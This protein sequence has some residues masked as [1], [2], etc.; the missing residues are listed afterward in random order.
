MAESRALRI[1]A[2]WLSTTIQAM[3]QGNAELALVSL[4]QV[5][6]C[7]A[8]RQEIFVV[9]DAALL[10]VLTVDN[11]IQA[12]YQAVFCLWQMS[13]DPQVVGQ[14]QD[15][16]SITRVAATL[17]TVKKEKLARM[18]VAFL[19]NI[20]EKA[21]DV[22]SKRKFASQ[23]I[24]QKVVNSV[25]D[26]VKNKTFLD[27]E[28]IA[29]CEYLLPELL[30]VVEGM[31]SFDEYRTEV[32]SGQLEWSPVHRSERFWR[33]NIN[34][35]NDGFGELVKALVHLLDS[36]PTYE[37]WRPLSTSSNQRCSCMVVVLYRD[38]I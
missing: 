12:Q 21:E 4:Q 32:M 6:W 22:Q 17:R 8:L 7:P 13:F 20:L 29:D 15:S 30:V 1:Y 26:F 23:M 31:S 10:N 19:R 5:L 34:N 27:E 24:G 36:A 28:I 33:D 25:S 35:I 16:P 3:E 18:C 38:E 2:T 14:M 9:V 37:V 11:R